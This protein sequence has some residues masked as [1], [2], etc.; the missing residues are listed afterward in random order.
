MERPDRSNRKVRPWM[1][2]RDPQVGVVSQQ[3]AVP[4]PVSAPD[5]VAPVEGSGNARVRDLGPIRVGYGAENEEGP[6]PPDYQQATGAFR[7]GNV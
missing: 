5:V 6:P 7:T 2:E 1:R 3:V 4:V